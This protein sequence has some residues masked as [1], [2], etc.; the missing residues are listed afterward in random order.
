MSERGG[1]LTPL[2]FQPSASLLH[3][4]A[5]EKDY[6]GK[7]EMIYV[8]HVGSHATE[9]CAVRIKTGRN[10]ADQQVSGRCR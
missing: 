1:K 8:L 5:R 2:S 10:K 4:E 6:R 7:W 3:Q 9:A